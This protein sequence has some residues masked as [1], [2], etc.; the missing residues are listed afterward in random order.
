MQ[1][2][3]TTPSGTYQVTFYV[4]SATD[5]QSFFASTV[6]LS[7]D[8]GAR[9]SFTNPTAPTNQLNWEQ[10]SVTFVAA[11]SSTNLAFFDGGSSRNFLSA[12]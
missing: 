1:D 10:F 12:L 2:V 9:Q 5:N 8:H 4:G 7:I 6:D 11:T 3:S